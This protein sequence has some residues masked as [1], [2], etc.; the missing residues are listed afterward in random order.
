[1][2]EPYAYHATISTPDGTVKLTATEHGT[3]ELEEGGAVRAVTRAEAHFEF[4]R[5]LGVIDSRH[6]LVIGLTKGAE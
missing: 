6:F 2:A 4:A 5:A 3:Y 1:M